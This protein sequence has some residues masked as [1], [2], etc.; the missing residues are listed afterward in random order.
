MKFGM[1]V[2][3]IVHGGCEFAPGGIESFKELF[4]LGA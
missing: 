3:E 2:F 4:A 1:N